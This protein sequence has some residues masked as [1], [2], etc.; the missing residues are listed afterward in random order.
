MVEAIP[1]A[2]SCAGITIRKRVVGALAF[3]VGKR[4]DSSVNDNRYAAHANTGV[5]SAKTAQ[6]RSGITSKPTVQK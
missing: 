5:P 1:A 2:S 3:G 6:S 4:A